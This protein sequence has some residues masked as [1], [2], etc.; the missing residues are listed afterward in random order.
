VLVTAEVALAVILVVGA[1]L[2]VRTVYNLTRVDAGFERSRMVTFSMTLPPGSSEAG[3]RAGAFQRLLD[4]LRQLPEVQAASAM[5]ELPFKRLAQRYDTGVENYVS[6][7]GRPVATVDY[8]QLVM[9]D[10][11]QTMGIPI[12]TG[13]GFEAMDRTSG[14]VPLSSMRRWR[15][16]CGRGAIQ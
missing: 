10:Y 4:G 8:Y 11:F 7:D 12:V 14:G 16:G 15:S 1:A 9:S 5:S 13:R 3:G 6:A 2:L